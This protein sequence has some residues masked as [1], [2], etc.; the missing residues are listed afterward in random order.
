MSLIDVVLNRRS[1][2][3]YVKKDI[4]EDVLDKILEAGRQAPSAAN[5]QPWH[6]IVLT[7]FEIKKELSKGLWNRFVKDSPVT[8]VGCASAGHF[9]C[10]I[11]ARAYHGI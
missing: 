6:F 3:R 9:C 8:I 7:E 2:R 1:I 5:I 4:P 10:F 11:H